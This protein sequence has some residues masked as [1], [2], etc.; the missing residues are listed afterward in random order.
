MSCKAS[1]LALLILKIDLWKE[2]GI[3]RGHHNYKEKTFKL[4]PRLKIKGHTEKNYAISNLS[5][6]FDIIFKFS[7][8]HTIKSHV[9]NRNLHHLGTPLLNF[10]THPKSTSKN[11]NSREIWKKSLPPFITPHIPSLSTTTSRGFKF[12]KNHIKARTSSNR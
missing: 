1:T 4:I 7:R 2:P 12:R 9:G 8:I 3:S 11:Q 6:I 5:R 10:T